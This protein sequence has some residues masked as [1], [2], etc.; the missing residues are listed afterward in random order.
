MH[1]L[2]HHISYTHR[3]ILRIFMI[4]LVA[5][6]IPLQTHATPLLAKGDV[7]P[8]ATLIGSDGSEVQIRHLTGRVKILSMVP[9]LNTPVCDEQTHRLSEQNNGIDQQVEIVTI[10]TNTAKDQSQFAEKANIH[11]ITFL[12]D[13]P[14]FDFGH[15]T[16]LL[17]ANH[18]ILQRAVIVADDNNIIRYIE[19][20]PMGQLPNFDQAYAAARK[21]LN[22]L[23]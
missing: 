17:L 16:K 3:T 2:S 11:N 4:V 22:S 18:G 1:V 10:S 9:Q 13:F 19:Q 12:S 23:R 21:V 6:I 14:N 15:K 20:V 8:N 7:L 5:H